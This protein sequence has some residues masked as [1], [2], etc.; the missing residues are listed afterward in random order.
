MLITL[1]MLLHTLLLPPASLLLLA[2]L[3]AW[4]VR[5]QGGAARAGWWL[6]AASLALLWL[7]AT[8]IFAELLER[9]AQRTPP[10]DLSRA[11]AAQAV[12]V[13]G[14]YRERDAAPEFSGEPAVGANLLERV[15]YAAFLAQRTQLPVLVSGTREEAAAMSAT[16]ARSFHIGVRWREARSRDTFQNARFSAQLLR[17]AGVNRIILVTD[18]DH[19]W[20]AANEFTAAGLAVVA[21]P[22]GL[23]TPHDRDV[24]DF[25][26]NSEALVQSTQALYELLGD[27][28]QRTFA[29]LGL[30][31]QTP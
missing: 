26:P 16:L 19:E 25:I 18:A 17:A 30:R 5:R 14:G 3:G 24:F 7:L 12:V 28:A 13:L 22:V 11:P 9:V 31:R 29:V 15:T 23:W 21:A 2:A 6:L 10:L 20:R 27:V 1:K 4:L 8:P